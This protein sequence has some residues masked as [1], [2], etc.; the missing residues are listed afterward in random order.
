MF[1]VLN[2]T[3]VVLGGFVAL[4]GGVLALRPVHRAWLERLAAVIRRGPVLPFFFAFVVVITM[5]AVVM[6]LPLV[7]LAIVLVALPVVAI[8]T[9]VRSFRHRMDLLIEPL[10]QFVMHLTSHALLNLMLACPC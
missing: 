4:L 9:S 6:I 8:V 1:F 7:V 10:M 2:L 5:T 3:F